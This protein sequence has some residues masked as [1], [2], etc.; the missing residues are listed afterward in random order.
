MTS[1]PELIYLKFENAKW[2]THTDLERGVY[3]MKV[4]NKVWT[5][6]E[7]TN[8]SARRRDT[9][10]CQMVRSTLLHPGDP[11]GASTV[12]W[13]NTPKPTTK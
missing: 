7:V 10:S 8:I 2:R 13:P 4:T 11:S 5:V 9:R 12:T 1:H 6:H 3:S